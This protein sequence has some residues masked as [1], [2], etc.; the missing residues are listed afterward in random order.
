MLCSSKR[1]NR[2]L[3]APVQPLWHLAGTR[4]M[5][6]LSWPALTHAI[7]CAPQVGEQTRHWEEGKVLVCHT[8]F[9]H[10]TANNTDAERVVLIM[11]HFHPEVRPPLA[12]RARKQGWARCSVC[13][14][15]RHGTRS[16]VR[17]LALGVAWRPSEEANAAQ[18]MCACKAG[19]SFGRRAL[20]CR[21]ASVMEVDP[22]GPI[23][24]LPGVF[25]TCADHSPGAHRAAVH[26][27]RPGQPHPK[28]HRGGGSRRQ[29]GAGGQRRRG[30]AAGP[31]GQG[32]EREEGL[33]G[34]QQGLRR[35]LCL[36][37]GIWQGLSHTSTHSHL[38]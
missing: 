5:A 14:S 26:L 30:R 2:S 20:A 21:L 15:H 28:R 8:S 22:P 12:A 11:R 13:C 7:P 9:M 18:D 24:V 31:R 38:C 33:G 36:G 16:I 27:R 29:G 17:H 1:T 6:P 3:R 37:Q 34:R 4:C 25:P 35:L 32:Q 23:C 19:G 10:E